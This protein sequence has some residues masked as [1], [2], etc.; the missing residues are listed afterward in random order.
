MQG[1]VVR[2]AG[3]ELSAPYRVYYAPVILRSTIARTTGEEQTLALCL[4]TRHSDGFVREECLRKLVNKGR[5]WVAPFIVQ[6]VGEY[7]IEIVQL[8]ASALPSMS[9][10][11][12]GAFVRQNRAFMATTRRRVVSYWACYH[13][14]RYPQL[15]A[16]PGLQALAAIEAMA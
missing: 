10:E 8:I 13:R 3:E 11:I 15:V 2:I 1:F 16:Y 12:Y 4:G 9:H 14:Q 6:L 5:P 7:V